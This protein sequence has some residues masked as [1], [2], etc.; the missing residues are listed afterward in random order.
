MDTPEEAEARGKAAGTSGRKG[1]RE[2]RGMNEA[3]AKYW[4]GNGR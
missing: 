4:G 3:K 1:R 2:R